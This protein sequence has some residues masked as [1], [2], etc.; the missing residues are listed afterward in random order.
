MD[1]NRIA[2][3]VA[4]ALASSVAGAGAGPRTQVSIEGEQLFVEEDHGV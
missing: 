2:L 1:A 4:C 3:P